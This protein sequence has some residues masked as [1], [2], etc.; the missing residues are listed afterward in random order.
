MRRLDLEVVNDFE[1]IFCSLSRLGAYRRIPL[2]N[3]VV[4]IANAKDIC[5]V[6]TEMILD[7]PLALVA[8]REHLRSEL[9]KPCAAYLGSSNLELL[10]QGVQA[11][12]GVWDSSGLRVGIHYNQNQ[13]AAEETLRSITGKGGAGCILQANIGGEPAEVEKLASVC[14]EELGPVG[15]LVHAACAPFTPTGWLGTESG[16]DLYTT[17]VQ[18]FQS[19]LKPILPDMLRSQCGRVLVMLSDAVNPPYP[20]GWQSYI[21]A[22]SAL[23]AMTGVL[24]SDYEDCGLI[25]GVISPGEM[26]GDSSVV[27]EFNDGSVTLEGSDSMVHKVSPDILANVVSSLVDGDL[28]FPNG[29]SLSLRTDNDPRVLV[30]SLLIEGGTQVLESGGYSHAGLEEDNPPLRDLT[31]SDSE[32]MSAGEMRLSGVFRRILQVEDGIQVE[33]AELGSF[34]GWDSL[35]HLKL[36]M[37]VEEEFDMTLE[38]AEQLY[39]FKRL[40]EVVCSY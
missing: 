33:N 25:V 15:L 29:S 13:R 4:E 30:R 20:R 40:L 34:P 14:K 26:E 2:G 8:D 5:R 10:A 38:N 3:G 12:Y 37:E 22:K 24:A 21:A 1:P 35:T 16:S 39:S 18:G 32:G 31:Q 17:Q 23:Q 19:L 6:E 28:D 7:D 9:A 27:R 36:L 11:E